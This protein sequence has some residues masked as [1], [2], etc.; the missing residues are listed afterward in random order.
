[1]KKVAKEAERISSKI[2]SPMIVDIFESSASGPI[3]YL[4]N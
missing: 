1:M 4:K 3:A 2:S